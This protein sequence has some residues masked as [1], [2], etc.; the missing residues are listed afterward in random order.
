MARSRNWVFTL[1]ADR[2]EEILWLAAGAPCPLGAWFESGKIDYLVCQV[3]KV[4]HYHI[5]GYIQGRKDLRLSQLQKLN[6]RAHWEVRHGT[7]DQARDY[8]TKE[9]SRVA[10]PWELGHAHANQGQRND[11]EAIAEMVKANKT[12]IEIVESLGAGVSK[13]AKNISWLRFAFKE[14]ESDRQLQGVKIY[15][16]WGSTGV[17]KTFAAVNLMAGGNDYYIAECPSS[18]GTKLW[19]DGYEGQKTL[20]LDDFNGDFCAF[21]YLL[22]VLD[23]YKFKIEIKGSFTWAVWTTVIITTNIHPSGW[24]SGIDV[25]PL[26]RRLTENGSE[27]RRM[28]YYAAFKRVDWDEATLDDDFQPFGLPALPALPVAPPAAAAAAA[29]AAP[30]PAPVRHDV[31]SDNTQPMLNDE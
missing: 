26:K 27:I 16:L 18:K 9:A 7:H 12:N 3:E 31:D 10:G 21:R 13:F 25:T 19:F 11:L 23:K 2:D 15:T 14:A 5:Q 22:R 30:A 29:A 1:N 24:F 4:G 20:I 17:G 28:E 8:C 6:K